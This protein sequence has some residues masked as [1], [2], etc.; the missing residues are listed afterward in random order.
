MCAHFC[1]AW[2]CIKIIT[3]RRFLNDDVVL[4]FLTTYFLIR[5]KFR[6]ILDP[7]FSS[8]SYSLLLVLLLLL[9]NHSIFFPFLLFNLH[10]FLFSHFSHCLNKKTQMKKDSARWFPGA[11]AL[12]PVSIC[13]T[14]YIVLLVESVLRR[15]IVQIL[16]KF[17]LLPSLC[18]ILVPILFSTV[19]D[20]IST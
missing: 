2:T 19:I 9:P 15:I 4:Y 5:R 10:N 16:W 14:N 7:T 18:Y 3:N 8:S 13:L 17:S 12:E 6:R 20:Y 11:T 1:K